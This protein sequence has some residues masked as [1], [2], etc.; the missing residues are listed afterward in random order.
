[1]ETF[2]QYLNYGLIYIPDSLYQ[3]YMSWAIGYWEFQIFC[4]I[5]MADELHGQLNYG[6]GK[7]LVKK[8]PEGLKALI[9]H[10]CELLVCSLRMWQVHCCFLLES[11]GQRADNLVWHYIWDPGNGSAPKKT[12]RVKYL[13]GTSIPRQVTEH[14]SRIHRGRLAQERTFLRLYI[15]SYHMRRFIRTD[16][17]NN[18]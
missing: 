13:R 18:W 2:V 1:M 11:L 12:W 10:L 7:W 4:V 17:L 9:R 16:H 5:A 14:L 6:W 3:L 15:S 8:Y